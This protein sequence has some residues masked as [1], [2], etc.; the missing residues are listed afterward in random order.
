MNI[1]NRYILNNSQQKTRSKLVINLRI[2]VDYPYPSRIKSFIYTALNIKTSK[3]YLKNAK[4]IAKMVNESSKEVKAHWFFTPKTIPEKELLKLLDNN[5]H[6]IALHIVNDPYLEWKSLEKATKKRLNYYTIHGT[7][8]LLARI[9]WKRWKTKKPK[10]PAKFPLQSFHKFPTKGLD[11][12]CYFYSADQAVK[13]AEDC[14]RK[15]YV[16]EFHPIWLF[17]KGKINHRGPLYKTLRRVLE[18]DDELETVA[19]RKKHFFTIARD[20]QEY[21]RNI[22]PTDEFVTKLRE[23]G[24]DLFSFIERKWCYKIQGTSKNW[25]KAN[26]NI[27]LLHIKSYEDWWKIRK[28]EKS[29]ITAAIVE[30]SEN[31]AEGIWKIYNETPIRQGRWFPHYGETLER[32]KKSIFSSINCTYIGAHYQE[33]LT[34]FIQ[35]IYGDNTA[36]VSQILSLQKHWDKAVNNILI[37]KAVEI[38]SDKKVEWLMYGRMGNHPSLDKFKINNGFREFQIAR[39][40]IPL[41]QR[42]KLATKLRL[43]R[44][45]KDSLPTSI[46]YPLIPLY[47]LLSRT[48]TMLML[49]L[50]KSK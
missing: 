24:A 19:F 25:I 13:I 38:C 26:D 5:K 9:M 22:I 3:D 33:E 45:I 21:L 15:G 50:K 23:R 46:K 27:A 35:L 18:V 42:G 34:G 37:S 36:M 4:I 1:L 17:Q 14:V 10:I 47:N 31:L 39:Y 2:D 40:Y 16:L 29:G 48:K 41:T 43:Q 7:A 20:T 11:A 30:P 12:I 28:A 8:R 49:Q 6:E 44:E 32:V